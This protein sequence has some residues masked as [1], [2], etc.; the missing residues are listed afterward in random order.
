MKPKRKIKKN[1]SFFSKLQKAIIIIAKIIIDVN[2]KKLKK[3]K[4]FLKRFFRNTKKFF[5]ILNECFDEL[6]DYFLDKILPEK[7]DD[8]IV[9]DLS[10]YFLEQ[11]KINERRESFR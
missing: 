10:E 6:L 1:M 5:S 4:K 7:L 3:I 11:Q 2:R 9:I 8:T